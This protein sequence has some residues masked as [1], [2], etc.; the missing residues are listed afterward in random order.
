MKTISVEHYMAT[1]INFPAIPEGWKCVW[2]TSPDPDGELLITAP[3]N[4]Q[5]YE[6]GQTYLCELLF[7]WD[8]ISEDDALEI[9]IYFRDHYGAAWETKVRRLPY[10]IHYDM[11]RLEMETLMNRRDPVRFPLSG[12]DEW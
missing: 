10:G 4:D 5:W 7:Y 1:Y 2:I 12:E 11:T 9:D 8:G 6:V 3:V